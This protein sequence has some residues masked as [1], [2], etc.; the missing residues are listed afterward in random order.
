MSDMPQ[1]PT[2]AFGAPSALAQRLFAAGTT[3]DIFANQLR[4]GVTVAD[5]TIVFGVAADGGAGPPIVLD[6]A[7]VHVAPV[8]LKQMLLNIAMAVEAYEEVMGE[9]KAPKPMVAQVAL[10]KERLITILRQQMD[11]PASP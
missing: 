4:M 3:P 8:M 5:F 1:P 11:G 7:I 9:I 6:K 10:L 2:P